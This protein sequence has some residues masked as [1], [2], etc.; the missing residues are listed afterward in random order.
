MPAR[1]IRIL[2]VMDQLREC[3]AM[4]TTDVAVIAASVS[5]NFRGIEVR[6]E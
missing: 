5:R 3:F 6:Y 2:K 4:L 1:I